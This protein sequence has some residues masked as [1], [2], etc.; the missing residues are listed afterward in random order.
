[1]STG[2]VIYGIDST[3]AA[4]VLE[5]AESL[6]RQLGEEAF[7]ATFMKFGARDGAKI[8]EDHEISIG[9]LKKGVSDGEIV[10]FQ[11][12]S[13]GKDGGVPNVSFGCS[14]RKF[15]GISFLDVQIEESVYKIKIEVERF[16]ENFVARSSC[17]YAIAYDAKDSL[18]AY[19]YSVGVNLVR[20]FDFENT[21]LFT[22]ELPGRV[23]GT[24]SYE[25]VKLRM[26]Y[27]LN[28]LNEEHLEIRV[29]DLSLREWIAS[30]LCRGSMRSISNNMWL[31]SVEEADLVEINSAC[32]EAGILIAWQKASANRV[33]R[34][35]P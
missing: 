30:D 19:K 6:F 4:V 18:T 21:S 1:M 26:I 28:V 8:I 14:N 10:G 5:V 3:Q 17:K 12:C 2:I 9:D 27:P 32:G 29:G 25:R 33:V 16:L 15:G 35:L 24:E 23:P 7:G 20:I 22:R 34:K 31:W 13:N 11:M